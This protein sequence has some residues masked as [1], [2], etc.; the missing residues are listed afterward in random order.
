MSWGFSLPWLSAGSGHM[1]W[2]LLLAW[3]GCEQRRSPA[4]TNF[5]PV[6]AIPFQ[7]CRTCYRWQKEQNAPGS[8]PEW[9][10]DERFQWV[11]YS[12]RAI[13]GNIG[14]YLPWQLFSF[15]LTILRVFE[16]VVY[17]HSSTVSLRWLHWPLMGSVR[18]VSSGVAK[19]KVEQVFL[20]IWKVSEN[21][22]GH[23]VWENRL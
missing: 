10:Q 12:G 22:L 8:W 9:P 13:P 4:E 17:H 5:R 2:E 19:W 18:K 14:D 1:G 11:G 21:T 3:C 16:T 23:V 15:S 7:H 20:K 6:C